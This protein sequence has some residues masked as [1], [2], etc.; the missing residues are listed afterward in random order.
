MLPGSPRAHTDPPSRRAGCDPAL[1]GAELEL[2]QHRAAELAEL[3]RLGAQLDLGVQAREVE[4]VGGQPAQPPRLGAGAVQ[5]RAGVLE[6]GVLVAQIVAQQLE[7][8][9]QRGQRRAELVRGG[10]HERA[11][12]LLLLLESLLHR[13]QR[14]GQ[15]PDLVARPVDRDFDGRPL[16]GQ[17]ERRLAQPLQPPHQRRR[18]RDP[19]DQGQHQSGQRG[20]DEGVAH[21]ADG[22]GDLVDRLAHRQHVQQPSWLVNG[23]AARAYS[24]PST[25]RSCTAAG[26][27][28]TRSRRRRRG[29]RRRCRR[30][31]RSGGAASR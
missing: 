31:G 25:S 17:L 15:V 19:E 14:A 12:C 21:G 26:W 8:P 3:D 30:A 9:V 11:P 18:Q 7:H 22:A 23:I 4:Q 6:V 27:C 2:G 10:G 1:G 20:G 29:R 16:V 5:Q 13:G 28:G 24:W